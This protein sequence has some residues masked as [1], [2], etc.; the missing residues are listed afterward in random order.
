[1]TAIDRAYQDVNDLIEHLASGTVQYTVVRYLAERTRSHIAQAK[2]ERAALLAA[3]ES[4]RMRA[5]MHATHVLTSV[6][7]PLVINLDDD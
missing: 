2:E 6:R 4:H 7:P 1:M 3:N 5:E